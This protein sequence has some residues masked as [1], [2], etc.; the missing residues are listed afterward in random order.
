[1]GRLGLSL[2]I[3][4]EQVDQTTRQPDPRRFQRQILEQGKRDPKL[5]HD[6]SSQMLPKA[7][8]AGEHSRQMTER[9]VQQSRGNVHPD[10]IGA[11]TAIEQRDFTEPLGRFDQGNNQFLA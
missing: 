7:W 1:V 10:I 11:H 6:Q 4:L 9:Q 5:S 3:S 2:T 8:I